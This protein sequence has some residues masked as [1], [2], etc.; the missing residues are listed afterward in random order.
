MAVVLKIASVY[1]KD[2][3]F[4]VPVCMCVGFSRCWGSGAVLQPGLCCSSGLCERGE[5]PPRKAWGYMGRLYCWGS[6]GGRLSAAALQEQLAW[7]LPRCLQPALP[8]EGTLRVWKAPAKA[9]SSF[10]EWAG[11]CREMLQQIFFR[12]AKTCARSP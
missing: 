12:K 2:L 8:G 6:N 1:Q 4:A 3:G 7:M 9:I 11:V 10:C 5:L